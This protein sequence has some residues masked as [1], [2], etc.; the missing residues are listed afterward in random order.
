MVDNVLV[1]M[2]VHCHLMAPFLAPGQTLS[3]F[4]L[5]KV[6]KDK[7]IC[8]R[9]V[10]EILPMEPLFKKAKDASEVREAEHKWE[11]VTFNVCCSVPG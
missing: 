3:G 4:L 1:V 5:Q 8:V 7:P 11:F 9:P 2:L 10:R 6:F